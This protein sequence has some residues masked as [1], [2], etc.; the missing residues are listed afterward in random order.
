MRAAAG[1]SHGEGA[2]KSHSLSPGCSSWWAG[3]NSKLIPWCAQPFVVGGIAPSASDRAEFHIC[4]P[5]AFFAPHSAKSAYGERVYIWCTPCI[6]YV[7]SEGTLNSH[8]PASHQPARLAAQY[9]IIETLFIISSGNNNNIKRQ[10]PA[11][12]ISRARC[13][14]KRKRHG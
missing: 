11:I 14:M 10:Q 12:L 7:R 13:A 8:Q 9:F 4:A 3:E 1:I 6:L 2:Q 5:P